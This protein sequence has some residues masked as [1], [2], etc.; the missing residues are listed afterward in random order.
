[1]LPKITKYSPVNSG[2]PSPRESLSLDQMEKMNCPE[3]MRFYGRK[4]HEKASTLFRFTAPW[5]V[6]VVLALTNLLWLWAFLKQQRPRESVSHQSWMPPDIAKPLLFEFKTLYG[7]GLN[8]ESETA[9]NA[10]MPVEQK[11]M[12]SVFH[13][14]HCLVRAQYMTREGYYSALEGNPGQ[15][16]SAHLMHCF[17]YL[18]QTIMCFADTTLEWLPAPPKDIGSTGWGFE[19]KCRDFDAISRWVEDNRLKTTHGIH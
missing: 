5:L 4:R 7:T 12:V 13:Q 8:N 15:V 19:H 2:S 16:S 6:S 14:L 17:D 3:R 10:L 9:W 11:A 1:M 18:R